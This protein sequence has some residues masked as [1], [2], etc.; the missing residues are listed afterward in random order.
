MTVP[1]QGV[2]NTGC[3]LRRSVEIGVILG[4]FRTFREK[5][6]FL[7]NIATDVFGK[8]NSAHPVNYW[9]MT[10]ATLNDVEVVK[11]MQ[12]ISFSDNRSN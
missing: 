3:C 12:C 11:V 7:E 5:V 2:S 1:R 8:T 6:P 4:E 10:V 9:P